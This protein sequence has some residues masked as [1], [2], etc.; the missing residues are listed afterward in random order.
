[1][2]IA[3]VEDIKE[4]KVAIKVLD[5]LTKKNSGF[6]GD[7]GMDDYIS[8]F[9]DISS[10]AKENNHREK[11]M[12]LMEGLR[13]FPK[14]AMWSIVLSSAIIMEGYDTNLLGSLYTFPSFQKKFGQYY[15]IGSLVLV[16]GLIFIVFFSNNIGMIVAVE[17]LLGVP[18]RAFQALTVSYA[19]E[20]CSL[21][22]RIYLTTYINKCWVIGQLISSCLLKGLLNSSINDSYRIPFAVQWIW[23]IPIIIGFY[24]AQN[25]HGA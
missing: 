9:L 4:L 13:S 18:W 3:L 1:M 23:P 17:T 11:E 24:F 8:K 14:A 15:S 6:E 19:S 25:L 21:V 22:L 16:V 5:P 2:S 10:N 20:I 7:G 12:T